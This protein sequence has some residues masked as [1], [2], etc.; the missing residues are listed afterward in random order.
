MNS[1]IFELYFS[2]QMRPLFALSEKIDLAAARSQ[3]ESWHRLLST[4]YFLK[5][6]TTARITF[7]LTGPNFASWSPGRLLR[8]I[9]TRY[10]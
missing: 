9:L 2:V 8:S 10:I 5:T 4:D 6:K 3:I 1:V 7:I